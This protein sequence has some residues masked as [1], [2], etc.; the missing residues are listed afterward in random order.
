MELSVTLT[1]F[2]VLFALFV[3]FGFSRLLY[4][5]GDDNSFNTSGSR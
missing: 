5:N 3:P 2:G 1:R 4:C